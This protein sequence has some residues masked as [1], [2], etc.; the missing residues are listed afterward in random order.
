MHRFF[1]NGWHSETNC[2]AAGEKY[3]HD[4]SSTRV[5]YCTWMR[6]RTNWMNAATAQGKRVA[7]D[8]NNVVGF[9]PGT[10]LASTTAG[11]WGL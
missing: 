3:Y 4:M 9:D 1:R 8:C 11:G 6:S 7:S 5:T 10:V 2:K